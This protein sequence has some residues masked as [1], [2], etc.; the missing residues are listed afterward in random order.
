MAMT[1]L[2]VRTLGEDEWETYRDVRLSA[3]NESPEAF[4]ATAS[5][6][7]QIDEDEWRSRMRR[8]RRL[9]AENEAGERVGIVSLRIDSNDEDD[10][11][12]G[13]LFGLWVAPS[14]RG[15]GVAVNLL[16]AL[17]EQA[18]K[19]NLG[20]VLY[21]VG[22]DNA[23]GVAFASGQ[24]FRPTDYRRPMNPASPDTESTEEI[25]FVYP[26]TTDSEHV[27]SAVIDSRH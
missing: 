20:A 6:E 14:Q 16:E 5:G 7:K 19:D 12:Y 22:T 4:A 13:E 18:R 21:W 2:T 10:Q 1:A 24:G 9:L 15:T 8:S 11:P 27:P 17:L 23:R 26:I 3:L 25:A